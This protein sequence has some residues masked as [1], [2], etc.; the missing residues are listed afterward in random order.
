M[1]EPRRP[2]KPCKRKLSRTKRQRAPK[3]SKQKSTRRSRSTRRRPRLPSPR[4]PMPPKLRRMPRQSPTLKTRLRRVVLPQRTRSQNLPV[5]LVRAQH[6]QSHKQ[7]NPL[8]S[9]QKRKSKNL[10]TSASRL[11]LLSVRRQSRPDSPFML[12]R[13]I[14]SL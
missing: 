7:R 13:W 5:S 10:R 1:P 9:S 4:T 14:K 11:S 12:L 2:S 8:R 6:Q 3:L